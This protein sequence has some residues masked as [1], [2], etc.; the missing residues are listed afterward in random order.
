MSLSR[1]DLGTGLQG[2]QGSGKGPSTLA[3]SCRPQKR[4]GLQGLRTWEPASPL[5]TPRRG[6][7]L[8]LLRGP[9]GRARTRWGEDRTVHKVTLGDPVAGGERLFSG[10]TMALARNHEPPVKTLVRAREFLQGAQPSSETRCFERK[11]RPRR[12]PPWTSSLKV[13]YGLRRG[14][15]L[16]VFLG[17]RRLRPQRSRCGLWK[18]QFTLLNAR[19]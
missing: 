3:I 2:L 19:F 14:A 9:E 7:V 1:S 15:S 13:Q 6:L 18:G 10:N 16:V 12:P 17:L 11:W 4:A 5:I 8:G